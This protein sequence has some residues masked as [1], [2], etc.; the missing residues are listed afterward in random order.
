M[1]AR[2]ASLA[3]L[4]FVYSPSGHGMNE[5]GN[6]A[7][8]GLTDL[9]TLKRQLAG[10][11]KAT[12]ALQH[13]VDTLASLPALEQFVPAALGIV[14]EAFDT[15][16]C[17]YFEHRAGDP[18]RLRY[19]FFDGRVFGPEEI[20]SFSSEHEF[21]ELRAME[22][23]FVVPDTYLGVP[24]RKRTKASVRNHAVHPPRACYEL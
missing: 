6:T 23:G 13:M 16:D 24:F 21:A 2:G 7:D 1:C 4:E 8:E 3:G 19:W 11:E 18:I 14:A 17:A 10:S 15:R 20:R 9:A 12:V 5:Y 22:S